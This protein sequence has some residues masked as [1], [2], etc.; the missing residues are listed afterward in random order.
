MNALRR[1]LSVLAVLALTATVPATPS[2]AQG[3]TAEE[4]KLGEQQ[5][6]LALREFG[7]EYDDPELAAFIDRLGEKLVAVTPMA[8]EDFTF[9]VVDSD[10]VNA[11]A[12]PG[13]YVYVSR[14]LLTLAESEAEVAGVMGHEIGHV[15]AHHP[16]KR[17]GRQQ[18]GGVGAALGQAAGALLGGYFGGET[19]AQL[20]AQVLGQASQ[21]GAQLWVQGY[22]R[23]QELEA[24]QLGV[25]FLEA[26]GYDP[27]AMASF[28]TAL[29]TSD[30]LQSELSGRQSEVPSWFRSHPRTADR[31]AQA[32]A[33]AAD[34]SPD[35]RDVGRDAY[36]DAVD[37][38]IFGDNPAQGIVRGNTFE[39]GPLGIAFDA[40]E[41]FTLKNSPEAVTGGDRSGRFMQFS[42]GRSRSSDPA[43]FIRDEW[44]S[45]GRVSNLDTLTVG[46]AP[47]AIAFAQAQVNGEATDVMLAA[48]RK[49]D[50]MYRFVF[51]N[52]QGLQRADVAQF[53][54]S[55]RSF[56]SYSG[57]DDEARRIEVLDVR[58]G[59]TVESLS[60]RMEVEQ[61]PEPWFE[62]INGFDRGRQL[63][64]GQQVKLVVRR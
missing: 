26:A 58:A 59:D 19:G 64:P 63:E 32:A 15:V 5:H 56:R 54:D 51:G 34:A 30:R 47:A 6:P 60:S 18:W 43:S 2:F 57:G 44:A 55:V 61:L 45:K 46:G 24:D 10:I 16:M 53:E 27:R 31:V 62:A 35:A 25:Q 9:T 7:G 4:K 49:G 38:M 37:G 1:C 11:F 20:G 17:M 41:G 48:I 3:S 21:A 12:I 8:G 28:L 39:H 22:S 14:G 50:S 36:L 29:Q 40:P 33:A 23:E 13:G 52:R 42:S